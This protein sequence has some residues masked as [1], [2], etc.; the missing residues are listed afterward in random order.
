MSRPIK[1][2][3]VRQYAAR[4]E[5][6]SGLAVV[7]MQGLDV[8]RTTAFR[9]ALRGRGVRAMVVRNSLCRRALATVGLEPAGALLEGPCTLV[10]GGESIVDLAKVVAEQ[11]KAIV[12]VEV[13]GGYFEGRVL[14]K[15]DLDALSRMPGREE[16]LGWVVG[17]AMGQ[18]ARVAALAM[19]P[20]SRVLGQVRKRAEGA[21][22][23][24]EPAAGPEAP[25][26][27]EAP[28]AVEAPPTEAPPA[29]EAPPAEPPPAQAA[30]GQAPTAEAPPASEGEAK[31]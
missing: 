24:G 27:A 26:A 2:Q 5:G 29:A 31:P 20:A 6:V 16:L 23:E 1:E 14:S 19:A 22:E 18:G 28:P 7:R 13:R 9:A 3:M 21:A 15:D 8:Q 25:P 17:L 12:E 4:F 10:W 30:P 11:A